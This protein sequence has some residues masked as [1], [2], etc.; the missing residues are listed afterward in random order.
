VSRDL[1]MPASPDSTT[2]PS[3]PLALDQRRNSNSNS[4]SRPTSAVRA[5]PC[6]ASNRPSTE[7][8]LTTAHARAGSVMPLRSLAPR[9]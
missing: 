5:A 8:T 9:S 1:P 6:K 2:W 7:L 3:P 4:S